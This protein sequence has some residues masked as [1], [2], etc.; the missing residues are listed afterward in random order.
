[1]LLYTGQEDVPVL[2]LDD[3]TVITG[4][5]KIVDWAGAHPG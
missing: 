1:M 4:S 5:Q 2:V 3:E